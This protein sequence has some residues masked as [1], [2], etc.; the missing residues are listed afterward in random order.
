MK[1][2]VFNIRRKPMLLLP[3]LGRFL[4][5]ITNL[6]VQGPKVALVQVVSPFK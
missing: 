6:G 1:T 5:L 3:L 4:L 2:M